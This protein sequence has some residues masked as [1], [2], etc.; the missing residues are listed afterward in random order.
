[1]LDM[2]KKM[3]NKKVDID[4]IVE[5]TALSMKEINKL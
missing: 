5:V 1:M 4:T 2:A 3:K